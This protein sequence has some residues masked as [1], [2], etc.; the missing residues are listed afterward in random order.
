[1]RKVLAIALVIALAAVSI[2]QAT[3]DGLQPCDSRAAGFV[4]DL[5]DD[6]KDANR[7]EI[8]ASFMAIQFIG[9]KWGLQITRSG[10]RFFLRSVR[11]R[12]VYRQ[13]PREVSPGHI[14]QVTAAV[15]TEPVIH[16]VSLSRGIAIELKN[17]VTA[18]IAGADQ[19]NGRMGL[20]GDL[21]Y[22]YADG[23]CASAWSPDSGTR[24]ERLED[25]FG[26]LMTQASLPTRLLQLFWEK[27]VAAKLNLYSGSAT[28]PVNQYLII[29]PAG[30]AIAAVGALPLLIAWIVTLIPKRLQRKR[31][32]VV[33]SGALSYGFTCFIG[34]ILLPFFLVGSQ[35]SAELA[36]DGHSDL[37]FTLD[38]IGKYAVY[39]LLNAGLVFAFAVPIYLRQKWWPSLVAPKMG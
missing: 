26:N 35:L 8:V 12:W 2:S 28:M 15:S 10:D 25:I 11:F 32:F 36:V 29:I 22:F 5:S 21:Y 38:F 33:V 7:G 27:R 6:T 23:K 4:E 19:A 24:P 16:T 3:A 18:E 34:V 14:V 13:S 17:A 20:D 31:R 37:A 39:V 30:I 1:M 9:G